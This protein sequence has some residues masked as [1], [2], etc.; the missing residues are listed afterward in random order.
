MKKL[1]IVSAI[2]AVLAG[3]SKVEDDKNVDNAWTY[4]GHDCVTKVVAIEGHKYVIMDGWYSGS[5]IHAAS[6]ECMNK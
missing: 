2:C 3:C 5:I 6:C 4:H 1:L